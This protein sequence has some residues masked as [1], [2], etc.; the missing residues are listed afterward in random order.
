MLADVVDE[1]ETIVID[2]TGTRPPAK[3]EIRLELPINNPID[4]SVTSDAG[5]ADQTEVLRVGDLAAADAVSTEG[6]TLIA[7][8]LCIAAGPRRGTLFPIRMGRNL[9]GRSSANHIV[10]NLVMS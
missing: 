6:T 2:I 5:D 3:E 1:D 7:A 10:M 8:W 4:S 9:V